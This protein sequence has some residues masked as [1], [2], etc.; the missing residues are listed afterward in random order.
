MFSLVFP[1]QGSEIEMLSSAEC[2]AFIGSFDLF[3]DFFVCFFIYD[4]SAH[5]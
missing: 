2:S 3:Y 4:S 5:S 1:S